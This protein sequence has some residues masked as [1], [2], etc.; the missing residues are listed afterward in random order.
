MVDNN[1]LLLLLLFGIRGCVAGFLLYE[2]EKKN[3]QMNKEK[4]PAEDTLYISH[5]RLCI[6][7][8]WRERNKLQRE[9]NALFFL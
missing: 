1:F 9:E 8:L 3:D 6:S 5:S 7:W 4:Q 2:E